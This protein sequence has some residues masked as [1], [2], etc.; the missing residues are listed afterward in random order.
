MAGKTNLTATLFSQKKLLGRAHTS[1]LKSDAQESIP[2]NIQVSSQTI[3]GEPI[4]ENPSQTLYLLQSASAGASSTVEYVDFVVSPIAGTSY[5]ANTGSFGNV[6]FGGGDEE[7][8]AGTHGYKLVMTGN[9]EQLSSNSRAGNGQFD[10]DKTIFETLGKVQLIPPSFSNEGANPYYLKLYKGDPADATNEITSLDETDWQ[11]DYYNGIVFL[12]DFQ[13]TRVP[14]YARGF[15]YVGKMVAETTGSGGL[16]GSLTIDH[17]ADNRILTS[18]NNTTIQGEANLTFDGSTLNVSSTTGGVV[19]PRMTTSQRDLISATNGTMI[20]NTTD[21]AFQFYQNGAWA[22][23]GSGGG[24]GGGTSTVITTGNGILV[25]SDDG[26]GGSHRAL[27]NLYNISAS[28]YSSKII[29][30]A[31]TA[32]SPVGPFVLPRKFYFNENGVWF[33]SSF[34]SLNTSVAST[35]SISKPDLHDILHLNGNNQE[36]RAILNN[37]NANSASYSGRAIYISNTGSSGSIGPFIRANKYYFNEN[38][39]WFP[40]VFSGQ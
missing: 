35:A 8:S 20:Y 30:L 7:T 37:F 16:S 33:P 29:Y 14:T 17:V 4:P 38:G 24:G 40:S 21:N 18:V 1:N 3:F 9:Y 36:D 28:A 31:N 15:L 12:Q 22:L 26:A 32:S 27:L 25:L 34:S 10:N 39:I 19:I 11:I 5:D 2:S 13:T 6:G 23:L